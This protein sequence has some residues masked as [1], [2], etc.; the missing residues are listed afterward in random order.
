MNVNSIRSAESSFRAGRS[1]VILCFRDPFPYD[2]NTVVE[3]H[4]IFRLNAQKLHKIKD[5]NM[6][7][8]TSFSLFRLWFSLDFLILVI[9]GLLNCTIA[10][11]STVSVNHTLLVIGALTLAVQHM[12]RQQ[13]K[14]K[15]SQSCHQDSCP[16]KD[17][18]SNLRAFMNIG[19]AMM[20]LAVDFPIFPRRFAKTEVYGTGLMDIGVGA[21]I[22]GN[23]IVSPD[24]RGKFSVSSK[25]N[26]LFLI[27]KKELNGAAPLFILGVARLLCVKGS[28]YH[29]HVTEYGIHWNFF[30]T[31]SCIKVTLISSC[32]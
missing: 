13:A 22:L 12:F 27:I 10:A 25:H 7:D 6:T 11:N 18:V 1:W 4:Y 30:F 14:R 21:F 8:T 20:I 5:S 24:A 26:Q 15:V 19:T 17:Y 29:E 2:R 32:F 28:S 16:K 9:P 3:S 23:G 31:L